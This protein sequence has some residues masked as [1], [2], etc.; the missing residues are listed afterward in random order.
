MLSHSSYA[1]RCGAALICVVAGDF[2]LGV[3]SMRTAARGTPSAT[4][5]YPAKG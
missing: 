3:R 1:V 4:L 2:E 5:L